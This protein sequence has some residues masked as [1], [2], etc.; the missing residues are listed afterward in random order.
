MQY[1]VAFGVLDTSVY[2]INGNVRMGQ[3]ISAVRWYYSV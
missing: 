2:S 1:A 3:R